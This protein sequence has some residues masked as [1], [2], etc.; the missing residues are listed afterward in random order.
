MRNNTSEICHNN[1]KHSGK[2]DKREMNHTKSVQVFGAELV[3]MVDEIHL[4][5]YDRM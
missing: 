2:H 3:R 5:L 4:R 1:Y